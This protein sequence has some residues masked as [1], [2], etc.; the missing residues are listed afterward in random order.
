MLLFTHML[1]VS[2]T[3]ILIVTAP[4]IFPLGSVARPAQVFLTATSQRPQLLLDLMMLLWPSAR[5]MNNFIIRSWPLS[6]HSPF[7]S[8]WST[9]IGS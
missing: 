1:A 7:P 4:V 9:P 6:G 8:L 3:P 5:L 2:L